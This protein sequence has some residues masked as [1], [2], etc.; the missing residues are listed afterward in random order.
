MCFHVCLLLQWT[1]YCATQD[2]TCCCKKITWVYFYSYERL[3]LLSC[4]R[5]MHNSFCSFEALLILLLH[6]KMPHDYCCCYKI[7][8]LL[9]L[10][11]KNLFIVVHARTLQTSYSSCE[12]SL[13]LLSCVKTSKFKVDIMSSKLH[14]DNKWDCQI[15]KLFGR[16][17]YVS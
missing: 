10:K 4:A 1:Y 5:M 13:P 12:V 16:F 2:C 8:L 6:A 15:T 14:R 11:M 17:S 9:H 7:L 3:F